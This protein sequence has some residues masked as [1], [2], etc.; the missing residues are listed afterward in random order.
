MFRVS[1]LTRIAAPAASLLLII[2]FLEPTLRLPYLGDDV[3]NAN[4]DG[5]IG[6]ERLSLVQAF[7]QFL[8]LTNAH[9]GRF[10]PLW[11]LL[12]F[13]EFHF[14]HNVVALKALVIA[15][16]L[17]NALTLYV[18]LRLAAPVLATPA[19]ALL[20]AMWQLRFFHDPILQASLDMQLALEFVLL[21]AIALLYYLQNGRVT[22]LAL[23]L[24]AY[25]CACLTYEPM[26]ALFPAFGALAWAG[27]SKSKRVGIL[28]TVAYA[29]PAIVLGGAT[30]VI[31]MG[32]PVPL[33]S[34]H[35]LN[36]A[37]GPFITTFAVNAL[38][39]IPLSYYVLNPWHFFDPPLALWSRF[40]ASPAAWLVLVL[41]FLA[42]FLAYRPIR[43]VG[44]PWRALAFGVCLWLFSGTI[45]SLSPLWQKE[46]TPGQA[47]VTGYL[48]AFGL[49]IILSALGLW[50]V[51]VAPA[52]AGRAGLA[53]CVAIVTVT[54]FDANAVAVARYAPWWNMTIPFALEAGL[55]DAAGEGSTI[56]LDASYPA[57]TRFTGDTWH[58]KYFLY[59]RTNQ[60]YS[61][62]PL[63][64][65]VVGPYSGAF[66]VAGKTQGFDRGVSVAGPI[67][68]VV[69]GP[70]GT[71]LALVDR[72]ARYVRASGA[73]AKLSQWS[74]SCGAL[75]VD[76]VLKSLP[77]A[78]I[79]AYSD[80]FYQD[81]SDGS[82]TWRWATRSSY[83]DVFNPTAHPRLVRVTFTVRPVSP[84]VIQVVLPSEQ[85]VRRTGGDV[86]IAAT[87]VVRPH[88][89]ARVSISSD[90]T[91][92]AHLPDPRP[93]LYQ[94]RN[95]HLAEPSCA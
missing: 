94:V 31:H 36:L 92:T 57:Q 21:A 10:Y 64:D 30:Y 49:A 20:P 74:S 18:F 82:A 67:A 23:G 48:A 12:T 41:A 35:D 52:W 95:V 50:L 3:F 73:S 89:R 11:S 75:P 60:R 58:A 91:A 33:H 16:I 7:A 81:E 55:L 59:R 9:A 93:V 53:A 46:L 37:L 24:A 71:P 6:Y 26:Y 27:S 1:A 38:G 32:H 70:D 39:A 63:A 80:A 69:R 19:L 28:V 66:V 90:G 22:T 51:S 56:Y 85:L 40:L 77:T 47:Y 14:V 78:T 79:L 43:V 86:A 65:L 87:F 68:E 5:W 72:A 15:G 42:T 2:A 34:Q 17:V 76:N 61:A 44:W 84:T 88:S 54:T 29:L 83:F 62:R 25:T 45:T 13:S 4:I 8:D